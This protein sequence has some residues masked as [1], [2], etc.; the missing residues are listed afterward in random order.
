M[1]P[2]GPHAVQHGTYMTRT[3][4]VHFLQKRLTT[5]A[6]RPYALRLYLMHAAPVTATN[7]EFPEKHQQMAIQV[8]MCWA[9]H[10]HRSLRRQSACLILLGDSRTSTRALRNRSIGSSGRRGEE[11]VIATHERLAIYKGL[12]KMSKGAQ[13]RCAPLPIFHLKKRA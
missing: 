6:L 13:G 8:P 7:Q 5:K 10:R 9:S 1:T 3:G 4:T 12:C 11:N 2:C